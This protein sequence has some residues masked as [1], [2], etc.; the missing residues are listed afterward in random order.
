MRRLSLTLNDLYVADQLPDVAFALSLETAEASKAMV[1]EKNGPYQVPVDLV[2]DRFGC[3]SA[4][5]V[6]EVKAGVR[7][8]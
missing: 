3:L 4:N 7:T 6:A 8:D 1:V 5:F 2:S